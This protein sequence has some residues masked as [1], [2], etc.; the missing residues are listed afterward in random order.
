ME[1]VDGWTKRQGRKCSNGW[2]HFYPD[3]DERADVSSQPGS[4]LGAGNATHGGPALIP[5][6]RESGERDPLQSSGRGLWFLCGSTAMPSISPRSKRDAMSLPESGKP[7]QTPAP[8]TGCRSLSCI[9]GLCC[10]HA[11]EDPATRSH[12]PAHP[13]MVQVTL[14]ERL[15]CHQK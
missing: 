13:P 5:S 4:C 2:L 7:G 9:P 8:Q 6:Y 15:C 14:H 1:R 12:P 10:P 3:E 11:R